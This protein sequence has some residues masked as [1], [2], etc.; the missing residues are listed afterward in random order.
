MER[1]Y[2]ICHMVMSL[3]GKVTGDFLCDPVCA[4]ATEVFYN[5]NRAYMAAEGKP[6]FIGA[7]LESYELC[8]AEVREGS[9]LCLQYRKKNEEVIQ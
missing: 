5:L 7:A 6:L 3:D 9:A 2:I 4:A 1:P 8:K